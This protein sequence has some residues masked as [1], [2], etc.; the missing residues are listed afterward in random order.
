[1]PDT[2][3]RPTLV[4]DVL[5]EETIKIGGLLVAYGTGVDDDSSPFLDKGPDLIIDTNGLKD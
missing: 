3:A 1:M 2:V 5:R 4:L